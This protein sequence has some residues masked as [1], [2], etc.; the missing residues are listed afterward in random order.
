MKIAHFVSFY[1]DIKVL[2]PDQNVIPVFY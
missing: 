1:V 2:L